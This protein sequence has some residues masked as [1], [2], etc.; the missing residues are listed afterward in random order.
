MRAPTHLIDQLSSPSYRDRLAALEVFWIE[1]R[2]L[3]A[4]YTHRA[5]TRA[6]AR[7]AFVAIEP[8]DLMNGAG[9]RLVSRLKSQPLNVVRGWGGWCSYVE[10]AVLSAVRD[11]ERSS[12]RSKDEAEHGVAEG[13]ESHLHA[14]RRLKRW[15]GS[16]ASTAPSTLELESV[17]IRQSMD[18]NERCDAK[19]QAERVVAAASLCLTPPQYALF[20]RYVDQ[21]AGDACTVAQAARRIGAPA[22]EIH[23]VLNAIRAQVAA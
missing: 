10:R 23:A 2:R 20:R 15:R 11:A 19:N 13:A 3:V 18:C 7:G 17:T 4:F 16:L 8:H 9:K 21:L 14:M 5:L 1:H 12:Q 6:A 22:E